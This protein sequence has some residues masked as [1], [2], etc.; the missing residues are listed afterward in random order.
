MGYL[1][2]IWN[3]NNL[4]EPPYNELGSGSYEICPCCGFKFELDDYSDKEE[5]IKNWRKRWL[6]NGCK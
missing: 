5:G 6:E 2:S 1:C 4:I 3:Y